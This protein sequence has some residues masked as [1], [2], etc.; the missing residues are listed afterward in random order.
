MVQN[1]TTQ[2]KL[3]DIKETAKATFEQGQVDYE[4][5]KTVIDAAQAKMVKLFKMPTMPSKYGHATFSFDGKEYSINRI[6]TGYGSQQNSNG[7]FTLTKPD[8][9]YLDFNYGYSYSGYTSPRAAYNELKAWVK[10]NY[11]K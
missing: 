10:N 11:I 2:E 5:A 8:G 3:M 1:A 7:R 6:P 9:G 4:N